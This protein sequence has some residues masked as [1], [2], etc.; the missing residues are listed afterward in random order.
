MH[1]LLIQLKNDSFFYADIV[2]PSLIKCKGFLER[3]RLYKKIGK[4]KVNTSFLNNL[5]VVKIKS[6]EMVT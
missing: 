5:L 1:I 3:L 2:F 6:I 4:I